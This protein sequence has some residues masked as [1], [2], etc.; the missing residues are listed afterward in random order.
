MR[1]PWVRRFRDVVHIHTYDLGG[2]AAISGAEGSLIR[3]VG[4]ITIELERLEAKFSATNDPTPDQLDLYQRMTNTLRRL[5]ET[6]GI[7]RRP[8]DVTPDLASYLANKAVAAPA[9]LP[10][11]RGVADATDANYG[12]PEGRQ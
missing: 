10:A 12:P 7:Q 8:R 9:A 11:G 3:R 2:S 6:L 1:S 5:L 4:V